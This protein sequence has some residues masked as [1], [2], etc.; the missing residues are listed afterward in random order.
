MLEGDPS[1]LELA[2]ARLREAGHLYESE[3]ALWLRASAFGD[4]KDRVL[5]RSS[6]APT[7]FAADIAHYEDTLRQGFERLINVLGSDHHGYTARLRAAIAALGED[8]E[9][10]E[11]PMLQFVHIVE[12]GGR[13]SMS[14][15]RGDFVTLAELIRE[16][17]MAAR[18]GGE[19]FAILL[20]QTGQEGAAQLAERLRREIAS[21]PI[22]FGPDE[23]EGITAS[24][25]VAA[26][27]DDAVDAATLVRAADR[28]MYRAKAD[29]RDRVVAAGQ[30]ERVMPPSTASV[31]PVT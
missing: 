13:A 29:G 22:R 8:P 16:I 4:D 1:P 19:E 5:Q 6:G 2:Y 17:D 9:R 30:I 11:F 15:R 26:L 28:A 10:L 25:G 3:G 23:I 21:R 12:A 27:P 7:Y 20:P 24:F 31:S 18:Y 14:K